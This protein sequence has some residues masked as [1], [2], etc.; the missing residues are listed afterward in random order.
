MCRLSCLSS[1]GSTLSINNVISLRNFFIRRADDVLKQI[2]LWRQLFAVISISV[3]IFQNLISFYRVSIVNLSCLILTTFD[4]LR[5]PDMCVLSTTCQLRMSRHRKSPW[6]EVAG[7]NKSRPVLPHTWM[8]SGSVSYQP[9]RG[10][11]GDRMT[12]ERASV[13]V[14][15]ASPLCLQ[16]KRFET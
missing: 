16:M 11:Y 5:R 14:C 6:N 10:Q 12:N 15:V 2:F 13:G 7:E 9:I 3:T 1:P 4:F 8:S